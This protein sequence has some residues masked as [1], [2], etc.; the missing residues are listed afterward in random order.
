MSQDNKKARKKL[1]KIF[2]KGCFIERMG[3][4]TITGARTIDKTITYHHLKKKSKG[5]KATVENG[6]NLA[7]ENHQW[8]HSLPEAQQEDLNNAIRRWKINY[9]EMKNNEIEQANSMT[10]PDLTSD[11]NC[12]IIKLQETTKEQYE[13]LEKQEQKRNK[14]FNRSK[15]KQTTRQMVNEYY[16]EEEYEL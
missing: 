11:E 4:R 8:L 13:E 7:W 10:V 15:N 12:I 14:S 3:I 16:N 5:G 1:E 9:L 6:A 2:E